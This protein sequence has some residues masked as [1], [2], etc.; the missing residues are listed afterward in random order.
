MLF[1]SLIILE[2]N[3]EL[4]LH[5]VFEANCC[6]GCSTRGVGDRSPACSA[7]SDFWIK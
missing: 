1:Y 6:S 5:S 3:L 2:E 7:V 4:L